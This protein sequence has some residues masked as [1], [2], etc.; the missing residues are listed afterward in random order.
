MSNELNSGFAWNKFTI[1][2]LLAISATLFAQVWTSQGVLPGA[3]GGLYSCCAVSPN[4]CWICGVGSIVY[5]TTNGGTTWVNVHGNMTGM[6]GCSIY[7]FDDQHAWIGAGDGTIYR[8][9][10][11]GINWISVIPMPASPF[12]DVVHMFDMNNGFAL[13]DPASSQWRYYITMDGGISYALGNNTPSA[14]N[15]TEA[16]WNNS[17]WALDTGHIGWGSNNSRIYH[18]SWKGPITYSI[19]PPLNQLGFAMADSCNGVVICVNGT[20]PST[21]APIIKIINCV[22]NNGYTPPSIPYGI[23]CEPAYAGIYYYWISGA[24][25]IYWSTNS[26]SSWATQMALT[27]A[28]YCISM[29]NVQIGWLGTANGTVYKYTGYM[30]IISRNSGVIPEKYFLSQ[31]YPNPFNPS[32]TINFS[33]PIAGYV[34]LVVYDILG[35][36]VSELIDEKMNAGN[37]QVKFDGSKLA[38]GVYVYSLTA[39][40]FK[41]TKKMVLIK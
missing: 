10:N 32:T 21:P 34:K 23:K 28:G 37:Y 31:N 13:G 30:D 19:V 16:G 9:V 15:S 2:F 1:L 41:Q 27:S 22:S 33:L 36:E 5:K 4:V 6:D 17:Y 39:G 25:G 3:T 38:S 12:I 18:G 20:P 24:S 14:G 35:N 40:E 8:T 26:G 7:A 29:A 11:G